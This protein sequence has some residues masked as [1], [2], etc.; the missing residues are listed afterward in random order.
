MIYL[1]AIL[2]PDVAKIL[3]QT[4]WTKYGC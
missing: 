2:L 3:I 1:H 4:I